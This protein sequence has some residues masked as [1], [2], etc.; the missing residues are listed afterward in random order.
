MG[1]HVYL[2]DCSTKASVK[3]MGEYINLN[4]K[5]HTVTRNLLI[6]PIKLGNNAIGCLEVANK[7]KVQ[8][9]TTNDIAVL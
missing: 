9:F 3:Q 1:Q 7:K 4:Q 2:K 8:D 6:V 5:L